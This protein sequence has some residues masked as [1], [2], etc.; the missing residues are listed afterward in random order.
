MVQNVMPVPTPAHSKTLVAARLCNFQ[1][2]YSALLPDHYTWIKNELKPKTDSSPEVWINI[3][4]FASKKGSEKLNQAL[5][6]RRLAEVRANI[7][8]ALKKGEKL[9]FTD[10]S[11]ALGE[12]FSGGGENNDDGYWRA[13][14]VYAFG[15]RPPT[16]TILPIIGSPPDP[17][18]WFVSNLSLSGVSFVPGFGGGGFWG[19]I[20]FQQGREDGPE[21]TYSM[22]LGGVA[23]GESEGLPLKEEELKFTK[24]ILENS[25]IAEILKYA[26]DNGGLSYGSAP[27]ATAGICFPNPFK[28]SR[29]QS[30]DF[31]GE[32]VAIFYS[33]NLYF[34]G[35]GIY[36]LFF[37]LPRGF[38]KWR[39]TIEAIKHNLIG[40]YIAS[41][42]NGVAYIT[43]FG[44]G[45][46]GSVGV[47]ANV[48]YGAIS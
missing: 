14:E 12:S 18:Q 40:P 17:D 47:A 44:V 9:K 11:Q 26:A 21:F 35:N 45:L 28:A 16:R 3:Q 33:G 2:G 34:V 48:M 19:T 1:T 27:S 31:S 10:G 25:K 39:S 43:S 22:K 4:A 42:C 20:T 46:S 32:C 38:W 29:L 8:A 5:S 13:V 15:S 6:E 7:T 41:Q 23:L 36:L 24:Q 37:G 30:S